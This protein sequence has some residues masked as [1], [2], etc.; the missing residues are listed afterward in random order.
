M[1]IRSSFPGYESRLY[2]IELSPGAQARNLVVPGSTDGD[3]NLIL[4]PGKDLVGEFSIFDGFNYSKQ[5]GERFAYIPR[6]G[7]DLDLYFHQSRP[8]GEHN[9]ELRL[10]IVKWNRDSS[11]RFPAEIACLSMLHMPGGGRL[12]RTIE[13]Q[14]A[15]CRTL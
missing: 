6:E 3:R 5:L 10:A 9:D 4:I 1:S 11:E 15:S 14:T 12:S 2:T 13:I 8:N 7:L